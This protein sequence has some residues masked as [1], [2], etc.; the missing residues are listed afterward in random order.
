MFNL[1]K[2][3]LITFLLVLV[4]GVVGAQDPDAA[5][6]SAW[7]ETL[8]Y[9]PI[10]GEYPA[11]VRQTIDTAAFTPPIIDAVGLAYLPAS[12]QL[13]VADSEVEET[14]FYENANLFWMTLDG[15]L[16]E[17]STTFPYWSDE[18]VGLTVNWFNDHLFVVDDVDKKILEIDPGDDGDYFTGDDTLS[19]FYTDRFPLDAYDPEGI[20]YNSWEGTLYIIEDVIDENNVVQPSELIELD[21]GANG[22]F[23]GVPPAGDDV[24]ANRITLD[25][26]D[27][28]PAINPQ[29]KGAEDIA[30]N[31]NT[32]TLY[33]SDTRSKFIIEIDPNNETWPAY[34]VR[35]INV[36]QANA[37]RMDGLAYAPSSADPDV[38][39][40]YIADRGV[41]EINDGKVY[42]VSLPSPISGNDAPTV[43]AG[44][45]Q[46]IT[47]PDIATLDATVSDDGIPVTP[48]PLATQWRMVSG[49]AA[50][51]FDDSTEVDTTVSFSAAGTYILRLTASDSEL[52]AYDEVTITVEPSLNNQPPVVDAGPDQ[53]VEFPGPVTLSGSVTDDGAAASLT[54][55]WTRISGPGEVTFANR[56]EAETTATFAEP[57]TYVLRLTADDGE[58]TAFD[59][60]TVEVTAAGDNQPPVVDAGEDQT[61]LFPGPVTLTGSV[62]DDGPAGSLTVS[63]S[64]TSGPGTVTFNPDN[65]AETTATFTDPGTYVLRLTANDGELEAFDEVTLEVTVAQHV[66]YM[67]IIVK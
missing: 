60:V 22:V 6:M 21:P 9:D 58:L 46:T 2:V 67:P 33:V 16:V 18:P 5:T 35:R 8:P 43:E 55:T 59:E 11:T 30:F 39:S 29:I 17:T 66:L 23:D 27:P 62:L 15:T 38:M 65:A 34:W 3:T 28:D 57:G 45:D 14:A 41:D 64:Q 32:G 49:P 61:V 51:T 19:V 50:V 37:E 40:L 26:L 63:W 36:Q 54:L 4:T 53:T 56:H 24:V 1:A 52:S 20:A 12:N 7:S 42:E 48:F 13:L 10:F 44:N 47:L 31:W 25:D